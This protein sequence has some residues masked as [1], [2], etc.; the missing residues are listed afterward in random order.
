MILHNEEQCIEHYSTEHFISQ[1]FLMN[2]MFL[3]FLT[4]EFWAQITT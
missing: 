2:K 3:K 4:G 1:Y